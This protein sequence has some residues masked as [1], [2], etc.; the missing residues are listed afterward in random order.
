[1]FYTRV[2]SSAIFYTRVTSSDTY[3]YIYLYTH[4][5]GNTYERKYVRMSRHLLEGHRPTQ[6]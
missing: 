3:I 6:A 4:S 1:V 2:G 5:R